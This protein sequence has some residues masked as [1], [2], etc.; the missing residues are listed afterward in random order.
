MATT[1]A[2]VLGSAAGVQPK[3]TLGGAAAVGA[4]VLAFRAPVAALALLVFITGVVPYGVQNHFGVGGGTQS[5]GLLLS[6]LLLISGLTWAVLVLARRELEPRPLLFG[7]LL[8]GFLVIATFQFLHGLKEGHNLST[9]GQEFRILLGFGTFL[10][11]LPL[12]EHAPSRRRLLGALA[13]IS[14]A[15]GAWGMIQWLGHVSYG[16]AGDVGVRSGVALTTAGSA[17]QLQG[18]E[19]GFPVAIVVCFAVLLSGAVRSTLARAALVVAIV[20]NV[21]SCFVTFERTFWLDTML[22]ISVVLLRARAVQRLKMLLIGPIVVLLGIGTVALVA[23]RELSTAHQRLL[24]LGQLS[25]DNSVRYR[26]VESRLVVNRI[27]A[28][29]IDGSGLAATIFWGRPWAQVPAKSYTFSH[30]SY[31]WLAWKLGIPGALVLVLMFG[32]AILL[33]APPGDDEL[34]RAVCHGAQGAL[35]GVLLAS[36]TFSSFSALS[37]TCVMGVLLALSV[38][39]LPAPPEA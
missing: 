28:H 2:F 10:I 38:A 12:L 9:A 33:R 37:M 22:G 35:A 39:P 26:V 29:P 24:S 15:L 32:S 23:P 21:A 14:I 31:L 20:L 1:A 3:L 27:R 36:V 4:V 34:G 11:A 7:K 8:L 25:N 30:D 19:F 18:G 5:P 6:D 16:S 13:A 17:G